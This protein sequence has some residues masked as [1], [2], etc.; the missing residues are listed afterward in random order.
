MI[1]MLTVERISRSRETRQP[2]KLLKQL[3]LLNE[4]FDLKTSRSAKTKCPGKSHLNVNHVF[5]FCLKMKRNT[6]KKCFVLGIAR[7]WWVD[8]EEGAAML[9]LQ[10]YRI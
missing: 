2:V 5:L 8:L 10:D 4:N 9:E 3:L 1:M 7:K 6:S